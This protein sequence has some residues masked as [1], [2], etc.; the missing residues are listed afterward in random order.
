MKI[1][2][3]S[4]N[5]N[6]DEERF[7]TAWGFSCLVGEEVLL[8]TGESGEVLLYNSK[9]MGV[10]LNRVKKVIISHDHYDHTGGLPEFLK[11]N[12]KAE[13][14]VLSDFSPSTKDM[15]KELGGHLVINDEFREISPNIYTTGE[16]P[17]YYGGNYL[18]EQS[19]IIKEK[20]KL[21]IITGCSHPGILNIVGRVK[22][23][24]S[25]PIS[26]VVGG[27]H[28]LGEEERKSKVIGEELLD[29]GVERIAP[30]HCVGEDTL[31]LFR[32]IFGE[33]FISVGSGKIIEI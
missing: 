26:L 6:M 15:V 11:V 33:N 5:H 22:E 13:V 1:R 27:L 17:G 10:D 9:E 7:L 20:G 21:A 32:R 19:L 23:A 31:G 28:L 3:L 2:I 12:S 30:A 8:D 29:L 4:D 14:W 18:P 16:I 24:F 25:L